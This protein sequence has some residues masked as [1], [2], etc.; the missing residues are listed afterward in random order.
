ML[1][2]S[3]IFLFW[4]LP[5][6]FTINIFLKNK[7]SNY[8]LALASL[9]FYFWGESQYV[10]VFVISV[11]ANYIFGLIIDKLDQDET[12]T[13]FR[14]IAF[15]AGIVF[16]IA[17]LGHYK[18]WNFLIDG[19]NNLAYL[20]KINNPAIHLPIGI[21]F[22]TFEAIAYLCDLYIRKSK[23]IQNPVELLLYMGIFPHLI[24]GPVIRYQDLEEQIKSRKI[25]FNDIV[26]GLQRLI[27]GLTKKVI[28]ANGIGQIAD[29][30]FDSQSSLV[31]ANIFWIGIIAY[32]LQL[33][34]DFSGYSDMAIG[35]GR[36]FGFRFI[37]NFNYPY[38]SQ[39]IQEFWRRWNI[40]LGL[41]FKNYVYIPLGGSRL[42]LFWN[43][44]NLVIVFF[45]TGLWHGAG[46]NFIIWGL[47]SGVLII[48]EKLFLTKLFSSFGGFFGRVLSHI[49]LI[50]AILISW[51]FFRSADITTSFNFIRKMFSLEL[52][53]ITFLFNKESSV[54]FILSVFFAF[55]FFRNFVGWIKSKNQ[56]NLGG[57]FINLISNSSYAI[58]FFISL[59]YILTS[60]YN[61]FIY[62][63]F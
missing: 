45:L 59:G 43:L 7:L 5:I 18:Y 39:S 52:G 32:A 15:V 47:F 61:P 56:N 35:L 55:P 20:D 49:Y 2:N 58:F 60:T 38:A 30:V 10:Y 23:V 12:H 33:Y 9:F 17:L 26:E 16:N 27:I 21:S 44:F 19:I 3:L 53:D 40:S 48:C 29:K 63:R 34:F 22:F 41:W 8:W 51:V 42:G 50:F 13:K 28:L 1:F 37:E 24:A 31:G 14:K 36:L 62:F 54:I 4:F 46:L 25:Q 6:V 11:L 57:V